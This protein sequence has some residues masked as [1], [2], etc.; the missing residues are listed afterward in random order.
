MRLKLILLLLCTAAPSFAQWQKISPAKVETSSRPQTLTYKDGNLWLVNLDTMWMSPDEGASWSVRSPWDPTLPVTF[1]DVHFWDKNNGLLTSTKRVYLTRNAGITW[2]TILFQENNSWAARFV[3]DSNEIAVG[4]DRIVECHI[5]RDGGKTWKVTPFPAF[6]QIMD[7]QT[8]KD[9]MITVLLLAPGTQGTFLATTY[10]YGNTW[11]F[12]A[13]GV[14]YD[15]FSFA[16]DQ[17]DTNIRYIVNEETFIPSD[18]VAKFYYSYDRGSS[19]RETLLTN[20]T[21]YFSGA[22]SVS[23]GSVVF[24]QTMTEGLIRSTDNG[25]SWSSIGGPIG[26]PDTRLIHASSDNTIYAADRDGSIWKT[27]NGGGSPAYNPFRNKIFTEPNVLFSRMNVSVCSDSLDTLSYSVM[28]CT[29][30][31]ITSITLAGTNKDD[32]EIIYQD[33]DTVIIKFK[34]KAAGNRAAN[35]LFVVDN[36]T[37]FTVPLLGEGFVPKGTITISPD[38]LFLGDTISVCSAISRKFVLTSEA[39]VQPSVTNASIS[40][41]GQYDYSITTQLPNTLTGSDTISIS[42]LPKVGG[43]RNAVYTIYL[44]DGRRITIPLVG[45]GIDDVTTASS[46]TDSLFRDSPVQL[47]SK[48]TKSFIIRSSSCLPRSISSESLWGVDVLDYTLDKKA[49]LILTGNDTVTIT[50]TP[51]FVGKHS[52]T[53]TLDIDNNTS[54]VVSLDADGIDTGYSLTITEDTLFA[55]DPI[56]LCASRKASFVIHSAGCIM[57]NVSWQTTAGIASS[58]YVL[59]RQAPSTLSGN[60]TIIVLFT[61]KA[62]GERNAEYMLMLGDSTMLRVPLVGMGINPPYLITSSPD[63][64]FIDDTLYLCEETS[65]GV[66]FAKSGCA[67]L[68]V[69][70]QR[71]VGNGAVDYS[72]LTPIPD[73]LTD[74]NLAVIG[75]APNTSGIRNAFYEITLDDSSKIT[76]PLVGYGEPTRPLTLGSLDNLTTRTLGADISVPIIINGSIRPETVELTIDFNRNLE[77][78]GTY[79]SDGSTRL[80]V[81]NTTTKYH[82]RIRIPASYL[83]PNAISAYS[84]FTVYVDTEMTTLVALDSLSVI[85]PEAPCAYTIDTRA[86]CLITGPEGCGVVTISNFLRYGDVPDLIIHPNPAS[87]NVTLA[88][89]KPLGLITIEISDELGIVH[90]REERIMKT[91]TEQLDIS[92]IPTGKYH[93][94]ITSD[95]F[96]TTLGLVITR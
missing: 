41:G 72:L 61:P 11:S 18:N 45:T 75:F 29:G 9:G 47:C 10:D 24:M 25:A 30:F 6:K 52:A 95:S 51:S 23:P 19:W 34:P 94:Q 16:F 20:N 58:D 67:I 27:T 7:V 38:T 53:Y 4:V 46:T 74:D 81:P 55:S 64:L 5:T 44:S 83:R 86:S 36:G 12:M 22:I 15:C 33:A 1:E 13:T 90:V 39:C 49:P 42:F 14:D 68:R 28:K 82:S 84:R 60:D 40:G 32:Y 54:I 91:R 37:T 2:D 63:S 35:L 87:E 57:P 78:S 70:S 3:A 80:D 96:A 79:S 76:I 59:L 50:F 48:Q 77:Y 56:D 43:D 31:V 88:S 69:A 26:I 21:N 66:R 93:I 92:R 62:K 85:S 65:R 73:S 8:R 89:E 17:C 71:I